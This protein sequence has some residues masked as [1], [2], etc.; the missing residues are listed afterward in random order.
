MPSK[1]K[2][3]KTKIGWTPF[4]KAAGSWSA[5]PLDREL[6][7]KLGV[8]FENIYV[9]SKY[10]VAVKRQF[11]KEFQVEIIHLDIKRNDKAAVHD[12]REL[13]RIKNELCG[14]ECE[15][16][17]LYPRESRLVDTANS[18]HVYVFPEGHMVPLG[19]TE[20]LVMEGEDVYK[21]GHAR[22]RPWPKDARPADALT[23]QQAEEFVRKE[24]EKASP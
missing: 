19:W 23:Q 6:T 18:Y 8:E 10:T 20:R 17:E 4:Q 21:P 12:W 2:G 9:N 13:Q 16:I 3:K 5:H 7:K 11:S 14:P 1:K 22:Q 24:L 15:G